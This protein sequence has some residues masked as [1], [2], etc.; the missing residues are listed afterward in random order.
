MFKREN[1]E[2]K[3]KLMDKILFKY[4]KM[5]KEKNQKAHAPSF[6]KFLK[7]ES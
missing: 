5:T 2:G 1:H 7:D 4:N 6:E 3:S